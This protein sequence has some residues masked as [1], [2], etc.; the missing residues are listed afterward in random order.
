MTNKGHD[1]RTVRIFAANLRR[2]LAGRVPKQILARLSDHELV[3][4]YHEHHRAKLEWE[5]AKQQGATHD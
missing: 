5:T 2:R 4:K 3:D 1:E